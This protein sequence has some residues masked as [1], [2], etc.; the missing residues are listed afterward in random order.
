MIKSEDIIGFV[1]GVKR[2]GGKVWN[3]N[4][5]SSFEIHKTN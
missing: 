1:G 4:V 5:L 3:H 2:E